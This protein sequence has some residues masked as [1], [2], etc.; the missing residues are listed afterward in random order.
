MDA[1]TDRVGFQVAL[2]D[3]EHGVDFHLFGALDFAV[4]LIGG[5]VDL[6][7]DLVCA[8]L[9]QDRHRILDHFGVV[10]DGDDAD[11]L[12]REPKREIAGVMLNQESDEP[13]VRAERRAM[14]ADRDL[15]DV[16]LVFVAQIEIARLREIDLVRR[17]RKLAPDHAPCLHVDLRSIK[18]GLV[19]HLDVVDAGVL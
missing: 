5:F 10:A 11:L 3:D 15:V 18:R 16:V 7:A 6:G 19:R 2:S 8:Q 14:D 12:G 17:D 13:L 9:L 1:N 4:D